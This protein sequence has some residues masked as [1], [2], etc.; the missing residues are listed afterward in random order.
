M[1]SEPR[2][3]SS[4]R[5]CGP[6]GSRR[7]AGR[8]L[9]NAASWLASGRQFNPAL[10]CLTRPALA[11]VVV[12]VP[13]GPFG[14]RVL[15]MA[16]KADASYPGCP[17]CPF[18]RGSNL[19]A[20]DRLI[21]RVIRAMVPPTT[22]AINAT[23]RTSNSSVTAACPPRHRAVASCRTGFPARD[24]AGVEPIRFRRVGPINANDAAHRAHGWPGRFSRPPW[25]PCR[26]PSMPRSFP[27]M[28]CKSDRAS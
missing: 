5:R 22:K 12:L 19:F 8:K 1:P 6:P 21:P 14:K 26:S 13:V 28:A 11:V 16:P 20:R 3:D 27:S 15:G 4:R 17:P 2:A 24:G 23:L 10:A 18:H 9:A 25:M 7:H